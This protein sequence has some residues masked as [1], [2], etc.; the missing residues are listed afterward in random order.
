MSYLSLI[1]KA[2]KDIDSVKEFIELIENSSDLF[3]SVGI[4]VSFKGK[5]IF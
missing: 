5:T 2:K 3:K 1:E 4:S